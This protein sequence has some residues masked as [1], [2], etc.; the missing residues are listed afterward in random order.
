MCS[1]RKK[2]IEQKKAEKAARG[3]T[4]YLEG[5]NITLSQTPAAC[6]AYTNIS[7]TPSKKWKKKKHNEIRV[8]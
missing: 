2:A 8:F 5:N 3:K 6:S 4:D 7:P 1:Q